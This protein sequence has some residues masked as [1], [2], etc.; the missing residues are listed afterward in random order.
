MRASFSFRFI[1]TLAFLTLVALVGFS[2]PANAYGSPVAESPSYYG[3]LYPQYIQTS[4]YVH[5]LMGGTA[6]GYVPVVTTHMYAPP[7]QPVYAYP[8]YP[9]YA[10]TVNVYSNP[11]IATGISIPKEKY[12]K[13]GGLYHSK[14]K[15]NTKIT[16]NYNN[17]SFQFSKKSKKSNH[18]SGNWLDE[19]DEYCDDHW[20]C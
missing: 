20:F 17:S 13:Y 6:Y 8:S 1:L 18:D 2:N 10:P 3:N 11:T 4:A 15:Y 14:D 9:T 12:S 5:P 7:A 16:V 19:L